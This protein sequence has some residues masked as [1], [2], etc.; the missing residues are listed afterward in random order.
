MPAD[1][2]LSRAEVTRASRMIER[3]R[4]ADRLLLAL[5]DAEQLDA[6][7]SGTP[8][9]RRRR[10][11]DRADQRTHRGSCAADRVGASPDSSRLAHRAGIPEGC[12]SPRRADLK[13]LLTD[14][15]Y[16]SEER[17]DRLAS[18]RH[19]GSSRR[20]KVSRAEDVRPDTG[21][22]AMRVW[23]VHPTWSIGYLASRFAAAIA[24]CRALRGCAHHS[25]GDQ[26]FAI[27]AAAR[28]PVARRV[29]QLR[30]PADDTAA[31]P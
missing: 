4:V 12:G 5:R 23:R 28:R 15:R 11:G 10:G 7:L 3:T 25:S 2:G 8:L 31:R 17:S 30:P 27:C 14:S 6:V 16:P 1:I 18:L 13:T 29:A 19:G 26:G 22:I 9:G 21:R 20:P 24:S